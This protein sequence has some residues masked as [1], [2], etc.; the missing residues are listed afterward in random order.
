MK[1]LTIAPATLTG[2]KRERDEHPNDFVD[3]DRPWIDSTEMMFGF[4]RTPQADDENQRNRAEFDGG[5]RLMAHEIVDDQADGGA[6]MSPA[7][8]ARSQHARTLQ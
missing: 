7:P 2:M 1:K 4:G 5:R 3:D 8:P 6:E